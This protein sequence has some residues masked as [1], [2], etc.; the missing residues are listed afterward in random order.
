M[1]DVTLNRCRRFFGYIVG[2]LLFYAPFLFPQ[3]DLL[4]PAVV[5]GLEPGGA[6]PGK[7]NN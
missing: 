6:G 4:D 7:K 2:F 3:A 5:P 1:H